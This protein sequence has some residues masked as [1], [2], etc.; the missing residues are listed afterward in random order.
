MRLALL[1]LVVVALAPLPFTAQAAPAEPAQ[2]EVVTQDAL[3]VKAKQGEDTAKASL[4][5]LN[6][7]D[8]AIPI[9]VEVQAATSENIGVKSVE[10]LRVTPG[11]TLVTVRLEGLSELKRDPVEGQLVV[12]GGPQ[13]IARA[14]S[15]TPAPQP[16][17]DWP[18]WILRG[19][20][21]AFVALMAVV[22]LIALLRGE[23]G[24]LGNRAPGPKW[25]FDSWATT[26]TAA[27]AV[28]GTVL[29]SAT[30]PEIPRQISKADLVGLNLLFGALVVVGPFAFQA[31]RHPKASAADQD[32]G[33]WGYNATLLLSCSITGAA[34]LCELAAL[35]LLGWELTESKLVVGGTVALGALVAYYFVVTTQSLVTTDWGARTLDAKNTARAAARRKIVGTIEHHDVASVVSAVVTAPPDEPVQKTAGTEARALD[36]R[37]PVPQQPV[38][39]QFWR[40]P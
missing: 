3:S 9:R 34:V 28:L 12:T 29:G 10:P 26:L 13:P 2:I 6:P 39:P 30:L 16:D 5:I 38:V 21:A 40:L 35:A 32:G 8:N 27:G 25:S 23:I 1:T 19:S 22:A 24:L 7:G 11:G 17:E 14:F 4:S 20:L 33:N 31:L 18:A 15:I 36:G 37:L